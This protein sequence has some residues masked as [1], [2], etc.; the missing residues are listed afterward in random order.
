MSRTRTETCAS[1]ARFPLRAA[2]ENKGVAQ[3]EGFDRP[4]NFDDRAC[5]LYLQA[6]DRDA[7]RAIVIQLMAQR[8]GKDS[9]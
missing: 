7:R 8:D 9:A 3:C 1:C 2:G 6:K 5:V 4:A